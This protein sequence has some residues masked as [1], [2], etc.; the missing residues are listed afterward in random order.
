MTTKPSGL[1]PSGSGQRK[2]VGMLAAGLA[3][4]LLVGTVVTAAA[5]GRPDTPGV[6]RLVMDADTSAGRQRTKL[7]EQWNDIQRTRREFGDPLALPEAEW[8]ELSGSAT[9]W[10][11]ELLARMQSGV[12]VDV[13][14][15]DVTWTTEFVEGGHLQFGDGEAFT[16]NVL[17]I[18]D[19]DT[20]GDTVRIDDERCHRL[21]G[22]FQQLGHQIRRSQLAEHDETDSRDEFNSGDGLFMRN[23]PAAYRQLHELQKAE[24]SNAFPIGVASLPA[25]MH[26][27]LGGQHLAISAT[28]PQPGA[29][30]QLSSSEVLLNAIENARPR[31]AQQY[32]ERFSQ[33]LRDLLRPRLDDA[34]VITS[35]RE[36][37]EESITVA[38]TR[39]RPERDAGGP[40]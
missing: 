35:S 25:P 20:T 16:V 3:L 29:A 33:T 2:R 14:T 13:L 32:Y 4:V 24:K 8:T 6:L 9:R 30:Q 5:P 12:P 17:E 40:R 15:L 27:V 37:L 19:V 23:W 7:L 21:V 39:R 31:P 1:A 36:K 22:F 10:H 28:S 18:L 38:L 34:T 11:S 26:G